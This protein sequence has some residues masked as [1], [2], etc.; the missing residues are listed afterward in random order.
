MSIWTDEAVE[1][2]CEASGFPFIFLKRSGDGMMADLMRAETRSMLEAAYAAQPKGEPVAWMYETRHPLT[3]G[4]WQTMV[5]TTPPD[6]SS[7]TLVEEVEIRNVR[8]LSLSPEQSE[9]TSDS[10]L[11]EGPQPVKAPDRKTCTGCSHLKTEW[12]SE[13]LPEDDEKDSGT[14]ASCA[15]ADNRSITAYWSDNMSPPSWCPI[16]ASLGGLDEQSTQPGE[17]HE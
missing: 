8:P 16:L 9:I 1:A 2:A 12:W 17:S 14:A 13:Y 4:K 15:A 6:K 7:L 11:V 3:G 5:T 10:G